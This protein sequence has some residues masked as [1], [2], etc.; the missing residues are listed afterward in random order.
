MAYNRPIAVIISIIILS[1]PAFCWPAEL[2]LSQQQKAA[3]LKAIIEKDSTYDPVEKM[4]RRPFSSP[5]YHTTLKGGYVHPTR[6]SLQYAVALLDSNDPNRA[7]RAQEI[8]RKVILLQDQNPSSRW[9]RN[10]R[11]DISLTVPIKPTSSPKQRLSSLARL[12]DINP[13]K[14]V[15]ESTRK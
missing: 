4:I 8:L 14:T 5:G 1:F 7:V 6:D 15:T 9:Q 13:W 11:A 3:F 10:K 2:F 12:A